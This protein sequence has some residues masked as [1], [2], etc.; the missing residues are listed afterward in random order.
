M[1][2]Q[3]NLSAAE[4]AFAQNGLGKLE[5]ACGHPL[6]A[7]PH[8]REAV[9]LAEAAW[10]EDHPGVAAYQT[11][12]AIA[13]IA[14]HQ[15][16][17][18]RLL[19]QRAQFVIESKNRESRNRTPNLQLAA[20]DAELARVAASESKMAEAG[21]YAMRSL[22]ILHL[23]PEPHA[24]AI[25]AAKVTLSS[26]YIQLHDLAAAESILPDA[27]AVERQIAVSPQTLAASIQ[28]LGQLRAEQRDW[29]A[30]ERLYRESAAIYGGGNAPVLLA[31]ANV[32]KQAGGSKQE[33]RHLEQQAREISQAEK[34]P[35]ESRGPR[36]T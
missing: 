7:E 23:Q 28:L 34:R 2:N 15:F 19:L 13:L 16:S 27:V 5:L 22:E 17:R 3:S 24:A 32:L 14:E 4:I 35:G 36:G 9:S 20:I 33:I 1:A 12:L 25:A 31:L 11:N 6:D 21:D 29:R 10:G 26:V 18:A 8:L 30:A